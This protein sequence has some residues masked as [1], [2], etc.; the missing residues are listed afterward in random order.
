MTIALP[1][2]CQG[3][4]R[5]FHST[6]HHLGMKDDRFRRAM[7]DIPAATPEQMAMY[8]RQDTVR[9][10]YAHRKRFAGCLY[11]ELSLGIDRQLKRGEI[12]Q[13]T[14][15]LR[16]DAILAKVQRIQRQCDALRDAR[17]AKIKAEAIQS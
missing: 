17:I 15:W 3:F 2:S 10:H 4:G 11:N 6:T 8:K 9:R 14:A 16:D 12:D 5:T 13:E 7:A 1:S